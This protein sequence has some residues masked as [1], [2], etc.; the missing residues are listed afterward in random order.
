MTYTIRLR[1]VNSGYIFAASRAETDHDARQC[2]DELALMMAET[3]YP[4][5][6]AIDVLRT[7][8]QTVRS[9]RLARQRRG[10]FYGVRYT[11]T[12]GTN[13]KT[14]INFTMPELK[15]HVALLV[16]VGYRV[17]TLLRDDGA[18][19][20]GVPSWISKLQ[21]GHDARR[22]RLASQNIRHTLLKV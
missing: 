19:F 12:Y 8:T 2:E 1:D 15:R 16:G 14:P 18:H 21:S 20:K 22:R 5:P 13:E 10:Y 3:G 9:N 7:V 4:D 6:V 11:T 17:H